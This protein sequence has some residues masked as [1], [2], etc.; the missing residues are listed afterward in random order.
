MNCP[1]C[2]RENEEGAL[3]CCHCGSSMAFSNSQDS[4]TSSILL[5]IWVVVI[6]ILS[7]TQELYTT[8]IPHWFEGGAKY[9]YVAMTMI[10]NML[11][12][13]PVLAIK[14]RTY[15][16]IGLIVMLCIILWWL[17]RNVIWLLQLPS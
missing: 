17:Y 8:L 3:F 13:L 2:K 6:V 12:I 4:N 16:L 9:G 1:K 14:N 10:H 5:L 15:R 7:I 11:M